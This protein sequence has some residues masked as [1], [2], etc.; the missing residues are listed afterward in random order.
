[1]RCVRSTGYP[2]C[3]ILTGRVPQPLDGAY[4]QDEALG[5]C[6]VWRCIVIEVHWPRRAQRVFDDA[7]TVRINIPVADLL[8]KVPPWDE[9]R[10]ILA[11]DPIGIRRWF[12][13]VDLIGART[14]LWHARL[15]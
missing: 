6:V 8:D 3:D 10:N 7:D 14:S 11:R 4:V 13:G 12:L 15:S 9:R 1:M 2:F 5:S